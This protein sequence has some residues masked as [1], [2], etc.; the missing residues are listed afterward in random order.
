MGSSP[1]IG[2]DTIWVSTYAAY[3]L[4]SPPMQGLLDGLHVS[5]DAGWLGRPDQR[6]E[7][8][9][10]RI[11]PE[12]GRKA[13]FVDFFYATRFVELSKTE[14]DALLAHLSGYVGD[15]RFAYRHRWTNGDVAIWDNRCTLHRVVMDY[16][17]ARLAERVSLRGEQPVG[18][19]APWPRYSPGRTASGWR[20]GVNLDPSSPVGTY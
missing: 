17:G 13:L 3:E 9:A 8:P 20:D 7:H 16:D 15:P 5:Y 4:L 18:P 19:G 12:T 14:S 2:G 10:V 1:P 6:A 11:H